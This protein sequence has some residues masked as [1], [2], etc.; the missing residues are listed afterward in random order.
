MPRVNLIGASNRQTN[1][2]CVFG[3]MAGLAPTSNTRPHITG[4]PGYKYAR[5]A[6]NGINWDSGDTLSR[7]ATSLTNGCGFNRECADGR[8]CVKHLNFPYV[9]GV[10]HYPGKRHF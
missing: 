1:S 10:S 8:K 7:D 4:L 6:A 3:S 5:T 2:T 9:N